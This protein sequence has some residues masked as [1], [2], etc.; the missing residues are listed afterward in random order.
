VP[1]SNEEA[2][3]AQERSGQA[4]WMRPGRA[5][6][7]RPALHTRAEITVA[8]VA[9]ADREGLDA[10]SMRRVAAE[11]GT[12][13]ASLYR[14]VDTREDLLDLMTDSTGAEYR[15]APPSGN[16]LAD[17]V[18]VGQQART[19]M[20]RHPWL[21]RL[22]AAQP[23]LGPNGLLLLEPVLGVLDHHPAGLTAKLEA[24]GMLSAVTAAFVQHELAGGP[25]AQQRNA[26]YLQH[27]LTSGDY[28]EL[29]RLLA[30]PPPVTPAPEDAPALEDRYAGI[31]GRILAGLLAPAPT[32]GLSPP[33][34]PPA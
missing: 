2:G 28:P 21:A 10:V 3:M 1:V 24:F 11:L 16:W 12:G 31:L 18:D 27:A 8:A 33:R 23:V 5:A 25:A 7:G 20:R 13:A 17:L 15:L 26:A 22:V 30:Q 19:I 32:P 34:H 9:I 14:Y 29:T 4:I 6:V